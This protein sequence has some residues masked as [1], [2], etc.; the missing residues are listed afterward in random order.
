[1]VKSRLRSLGCSPC[2]GAIR[3]D[4]ETIPAIISELI[5]FPALPSAPTAPST[6]DQE[7]S[8]ERSRSGRD[9]SRCRCWRLPHSP[10]TSFCSRRRR[11]GPAALLDSRQ[12]WTTESPTLIGRLLYDT[13]SAT[14][15][16]CRS[17][18][19]K[20]T[21]A[22]GQIDFALLTTGSA[23]EREQ[24]ITIDVAYRYFSTARRKS[25]SPIR[26][27][28]SSTRENYGQP[29]RRRPMRRWF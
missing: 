12:W 22:P 25:S 17:I 26:P 15:T 21:T 8:M 10:L 1:M 13:Q 3:S 29:A 20:G 6:Y 5:S 27:A 18:E 11:E 28:T 24:G 4:A 19:G 2:T 7:G 16:R 9:I 23:A 14:K